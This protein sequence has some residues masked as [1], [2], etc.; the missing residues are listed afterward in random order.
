MNQKQVWNKIAKKY[1]GYHRKSWLALKKFLDSVDDDL[2]DLGA[3]NCGFTAPL[4]KRGIKIYA[5]DFSE[6]MLALAPREVEKIIAPVTKVPLKRKF[7]YIVAIAVVHHL[8]TR[9]DRLAFFEEVKRLLA[10]DGQA[11]ITAWS[12]KDLGDSYIK[13]GE[14]KRYYHIFSKKEL[15]DLLTKA[16]FTKF[17]ITK[18]IGKLETNWIIKIKN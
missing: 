18:T 13:W 6:E 10:K 9:K 3:G 2:L 12:K 14:I 8:Q 7:K 17:I 16:G 5:V 4:L 15:S 11:I 1:G